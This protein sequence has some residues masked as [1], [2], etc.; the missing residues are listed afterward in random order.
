[1]DKQ[2]AQNTW[3]ILS[4]MNWATK[5]LQERNFENPRLNVELL[6][7]HSLQ[8]SRV[9]LY[10][11]FEK[12]LSKDELAQFKQLFQKRLQHE[13][14]QYIL[15]E[16]EFFGLK[17]FTDARAFIPRPETEIL[18]EEVINFCKVFSENEQI[19]ILD[20][21]TG[22]GNISISLAKHISNA[23]ITSIDISKDA[24]DI[25]TEN[26]KRNAVENNIEFILDDIFNL[27]SKIDKHTF[28]ILV[29]NPPYIS[30]NEFETL[31]PEIQLFEPR[32]ATTDE[33]DGLSFYK[34]IA[35]LEGVCLSKHGLI[36]VEIAYNQCAQVKNIFT[37]TGYKNISTRTDYNG[38]ERVV[39]CN[40]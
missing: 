2:H 39:I 14:L 1:M 23:R 22:S 17:F 16:T 30:K 29:S 20:I 3:T 21:G 28:N 9:Q 31:Q 11:C 37:H 33:T 4:L 38:I 36:A 13:P 34:R 40:N 15:G 32:I 6:L 35:E 19:N 10:T 25:A 12:P 27:Q 5:Y 7:S 24:I 18:I 26:A 8:L